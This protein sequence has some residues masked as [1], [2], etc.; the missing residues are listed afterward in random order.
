V[1]GPLN[2]LS[3]LMR[4][5]SDQPAK[6]YG[7]IVAQARLPIFYQSFGVPDTIDG[8]F[9]VLALHL[10]AVLNRLNAEG[11]EGLALAQALVDRFTADMETVLREL[12][13]GDLKVPKAVR[14]I[15]ASSRTLLGAYE[16]ALPEGEAALA[17]AIASALPLGSEPAR[18][19]SSR[20]APYLLG[21][22]RLLA[23][24]PAASLLAGELEFPQIREP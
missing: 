9:A 21:V 1:V 20:L 23:I 22:V 12:G 18:A 15:A 17:A 11:P 19:A 2:P 7:A 5:R 16:A 8:R 3:R 4:W 24:K 14:R 6:L 10:F 13:V